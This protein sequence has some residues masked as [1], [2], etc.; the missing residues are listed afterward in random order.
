MNTPRRIADPTT[1]SVV[2]ML[3]GLFLALTGRI[4]AG[5][6]APAVY[7]L[8][9]D[10]ITEWNP[11][12]PGGVPN[13]T[14]IQESLAA[15][16][17]GDGRTDA[18]AA[19]QACLNAA[20]AS[21]ATSGTGRVV[22]LSAGTFSIS[23][24]LYLPSRVVLRGQ[25]PEHTRL[26]A[27]GNE[28]PLIVIGRTLWPHPGDGA[29]N[30][31]RLGGMSN[32]Q[33]QLSPPGRRTTRLAQPG[34]KGERSVQVVDPAG[35]AAGQLVYIDEL[36]DNH[37]SQWNLAKHPPGKNRN[38]YS[39]DDRPITQI[40]EVVAVEGPR[41]TFATPL[42]IDFRTTQSAE[43]SRFNVDPVW[44]AGIEELRVSSGR[45]GNIQLD[46][47]ACSWVRHVESDDSFGSCVSLRQCYRCVIRDSYL[48]DS[49]Y[50]N[51]GGAG[52]GF[53]VTFG[54]SDNLLEN[55]ISIR[56]NKVINCRASGGGNVIAYNYTDDGAMNSEPNWVETGL[57]ASHYPT[58][59]YELF[60]G[61]Y[62]VNIDGDFTEGNA[63]DIT[64]FR[65]QASG[66]RRNTPRFLHDTDTRSRRIAGAFQGHYWYNFVGNV[67]GFSGMEPSAP[68]DWVYEGKPPYTGHPIP[69]WRFGLGDPDYDKVDPEVSGTVIRDGN[70]DYVTK[71][72]HWHSSP[73]FAGAL[74]DS[75]YL[76]AKPAFF[77]RLRWPWVDALGEVKIYV[78]P[79][80]ARYDAGK[81]NG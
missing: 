22:L 5:E 73:G 36:T 62:G 42:H 25:G 20:A 44:Y 50:Y 54:S 65:N 11:G 17:F 18:R 70:F 56:F 16:D 9:P 60:E 26:V 23:G 6:A 14:V 52:Y 28:H 43:L 37:R 55:N 71:S 39:R 38:W 4:V 78:L 58:P 45:N 53:D 34:R 66:L 24:E 57:Q 64:Y 59:H 29:T 7:Q 3:V 2:P 48:H 69:V 75:L 35:F 30:V 79:A 67:L 61:N 27:T 63:I 12:V 31:T 80:K 46:Y 10:R 51:N 76:K 19:I 72:V 49:Y 40:L 1:V 41:I 81:P 33:V 74:P 77:G 13:Y 47:A 15:A 32:Q 8:P 21:A 68:G